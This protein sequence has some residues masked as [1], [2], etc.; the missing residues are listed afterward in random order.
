MR[1]KVL[2]D[3]PTAAILRGYL[4]SN[5]YHLLDRSDDA[6]GD[7]EV[8]VSEAPNMKWPM[9]EGIES[10]LMLAVTKRLAAL[11]PAGAMVLVYKGHLY[12]DRSIGVTVTMNEAERV[13]GARAVL[14]AINDLRKVREKMTIKPKPWWRRVLWVGVLALLPSLLQAQPVYWPVKF[15]TSTGAVVWAGDGVNNAVRVNVVAG[16]SGG[17]A[18]TQSTGA[19]AATNFWNVRLTDGTSFYK[20]LTDAELRASN[21][22]VNCASGCV[23]GGSFA[24]AAA[25]TFGT[26]PVG[27]TAFVVDDVGTNTVAENSAGAGRMNTNRIPYFDL[28]KSAANTAAFLVTGTGGTFP[29]TSAGLTNLDV[30]LSTRLK[31]ADTLAGVTTLGTITNVVHVD[32]NAGSLTIDNANLDAAISTRLKPADTLAGVT[33]VTTLGTITNPVTVA[34]ATAANLKMQTDSSGATGSATPARAELNGL[35]DG[36]N[37]I[38]QKAVSAANLTLGATP[39]T[40]VA[41]TDEVCTW[42]INHLPAA[43]TKATISR[44]ANASGRHVA[45]FYQVCFAAGATAGP[46]QTWTIRDGATGAGTVVWNGALAVAVNGSMCIGGEVS[47]VGTTNTAMTIEF[48][49]AGAATTIETVSLCGYDVN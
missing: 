14:R 5:D 20:G 22:N 41:I 36:T 31:P 48:G 11:T 46:V 24:D 3:C 1:I 29:V 45:K 43:A 37:L 2:G 28:S 16:A 44:A 40:G 21:V 34:Q 6:Q 8:T 49:A 18:V 17:G 27:L 15:V 47:L 42:T 9:V 38:G 10:P 19:G 7:Y 30:A 33:T 4:Q 39:L 23:A 32:D 35:N 25:F 26:T 13:S 12:G